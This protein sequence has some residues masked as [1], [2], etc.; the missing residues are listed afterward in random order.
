MLLLETSVLRFLALLTDL[1]FSMSFMKP[2]Y[3]VSYRYMRPLFRV[4]L[5]NLFFTL[6]IS[7]CYD[8]PLRQLQSLRDLL[9]LYASSFLLLFL[10]A[11]CIFSRNTKVCVVTIT[12]AFA[13]NFNNHTIQAM[14][15]G[16]LSVVFLNNR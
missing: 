11:T 15:Y 7:S 9:P 10:T 2:Q 5:L 13:H 3:P 1:L 12:F 6:S 8:S 4:S 14:V 16:Y